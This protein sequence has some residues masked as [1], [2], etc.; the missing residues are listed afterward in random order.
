MFHVG[1]DVSIFHVGVYVCVYSMRVYMCVYVPC[2]CTCV[3]MFHVGVHVSIFHVDVY[4]CLYVPCGCMCVF[5]YSMWVHMGVFH[6]GVCGTVIG[7]LFWLNEACSTD[8]VEN[9]TRDRKASHVSRVRC[10]T[11]QSPQLHDSVTIS[12]AMSQASGILARLHPHSYL[13]AQPTIKG[14]AWPLLAL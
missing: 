8:S 5:V 1:V 11:L 13:T 6:V 14:A 9:S 3:C 7:S 4:V 12:Q 2:G 10:L